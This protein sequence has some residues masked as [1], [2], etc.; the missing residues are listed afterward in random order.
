VIQGTVADDLSVRFPHLNL[1]H[2]LE[3]VSA[4][5]GKFQLASLAAG[6]WT[7]CATVTGKELLDPCHGAARPIPVTLAEGASRSGVQVQLAKG[8]ILRV[9]IEDA[10]KLLEQAAAKAAGAQI[11]AGVW[12]PNGVYYPL[13]APVRDATGA[14]YS[15]IVPVDTAFH[16]GVT[17][18]HVQVE[19]SERRV[20]AQSGQELVPL[21]LAREE[22]ARQVTFTVT[23][24]R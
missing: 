20:V 24:L 10:G 23:A 22:T 5:D 19:D 21:R 1:G 7:I 15:I 11:A 4:A 3:A 13:G 9:R 12:A 14:V 2:V 18:A 16:L 8:A 6:E 17:A